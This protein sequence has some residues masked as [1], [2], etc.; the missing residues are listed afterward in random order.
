MGYLNDRDHNVEKRRKKPEYIV[1]VV[2]ILDEI[3]APLHEAYI[4]Q[5]KWMVCHEI[6][7]EIQVTENSVQ[8]HSLL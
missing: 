5:V 6:Q 4:M 7:D 1:D 8:D 2:T 3:R